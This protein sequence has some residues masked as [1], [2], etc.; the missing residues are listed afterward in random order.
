MHT[1]RDR[2][3]EKRVGVILRQGW[4][5]VRPRCEYFSE[6]EQSKIAAGAVPRLH[7]LGGQTSLAEAGTA[8]YSDTFTGIFV[9][10]TN[11]WKYWSISILVQGLLIARRSIGPFARVNAFEIMFWVR[12]GATSS[13]WDLS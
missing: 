6:T 7:F 8:R 2:S 12:Y 10:V 3:L 5:A 4:H 13:C 9:Q 1:L 11:A